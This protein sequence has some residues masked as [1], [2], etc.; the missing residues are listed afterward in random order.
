MRHS[1]HTAPLHSVVIAPPEIDKDTLDLGAPTPDRDAAIDA[2]SPSS[3][4][5]PVNA[6][7]TGTRWSTKGIPLGLMFGLL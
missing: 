2:A 5:F 7:H 3:F 6:G 4:G 1:E